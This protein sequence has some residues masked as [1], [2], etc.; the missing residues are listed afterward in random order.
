MSGVWAAVADYF[1]GQVP[2]P[3]WALWVLPVAAGLA[4]WLWCRGAVLGERASRRAAEQ[5]AGY[6]T[7]RVRVLDQTRAALTAAA[8]PSAVPIAGSDLPSR[9][10]ATLAPATLSAGVPVLSPEVTVTQVAEPRRYLLPAWSPQ[11]S[12]VSPERISSAQPNGWDWLARRLVTVAGVLVR[13]TPA[14]LLAGL[15]LA[16]IATARARSGVGVWLAA[17]GLLVRAWAVR[18]GARWRHGGHRAGAGPSWSDVEREVSQRW[19]D[20]RKAAGRQL[21]YLL[22]HLPGAPTWR[23]QLTVMRAALRPPSRTV[24]PSGPMVG[25]TP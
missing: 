9:H 10:G 1:T 11:R 16:G 23:Q 19:A 12:P 14:A 21:R 18:C 15:V 8:A 20:E 7:D 4:V 6:A 5:R 3:V 25:C 13:V 24:L 2:A 17:R 22:R